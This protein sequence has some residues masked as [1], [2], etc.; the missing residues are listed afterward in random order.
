MSTASNFSLTQT[1]GRVTSAQSSAVQA[2][3]VL[4]GRLLFSAVFLMTAASHFSKLAIGYA[5]AAGVP[6]ASVAVPAAGIG[7][8][9]GRLGRLPGCRARI[10][11]WLLGFVLV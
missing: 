5:A 3:I 11:G 9:A 10:G 4:A 6:F 8:I 2:G 7:G 1:S